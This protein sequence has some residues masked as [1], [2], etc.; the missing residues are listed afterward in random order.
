MAK[1]RGLS[2]LFDSDTDYNSLPE[3]AA[4]G[5]ASEALVSEVFPNPDQPRKSFDENALNDLA[6]SIREHGVISPIVVVKKGDGAYMIVAGERR[7][8]AAI[9][10]GLER[11]PVIVKQFDEREIREILALSK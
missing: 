9:R 5:A 11:V 1:G 10:A 6:N 4:G 8:R 7:Y 2:S 3:D